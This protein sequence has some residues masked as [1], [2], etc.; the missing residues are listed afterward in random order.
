L[1]LSPESQR[2]RKAGGGG[3][4]VK[5]PK[6]KGTP[7]SAKK[8]AKRVVQSGVADLLDEEEDGLFR[9]MLLNPDGGDSSIDAW[10]E[11]C[12]VLPSMN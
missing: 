4:K 11:R 1:L 7:R 2:K 9:D 6:S 8:A 3:T 12:V 10:L 5:S